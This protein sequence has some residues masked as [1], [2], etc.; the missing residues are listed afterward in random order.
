MR[1]EFDDMLTEMIGYG[2][3]LDYQPIIKK[4]VVWMHYCQECQEGLR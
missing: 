2:E 3:Y 4:F 1:Q